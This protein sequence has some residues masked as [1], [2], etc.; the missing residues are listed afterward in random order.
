VC[1]E[2]VVE[3]PHDRDNLSRMSDTEDDVSNLGYLWPSQRGWMVPPMMRDLDRLQL[4]NQI[5]L[6]NRQV[7]K[8]G[9]RLVQRAVIDDLADPFAE[10]RRRRV[11]TV[12]VYS[13][14]DEDEF[15]LMWRLVKKSIK[16]SE[17]QLLPY[18]RHLA[19]ESYG[20]VLFA[21]TPTAVTRS[22][23]IEGL[24]EGSK[25]VFKDVVKQFGVGVS[26]AAIVVVGGMI[27]L[28][29]LL[30]EKG[31]EHKTQSAVIVECPVGEAL[32]VNSQMLD[33]RTTSELLKA[34]NS[35]C[36]VIGRFDLHPD[37]K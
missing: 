10:V 32:N 22:E 28:G 23:F 21:E 13:Q 17:Y 31:D 26:T 34:M 18:E 6:L 5:E 3:R 35:H 7:Y 37:K 25:D 14:G 24:K 4:V 2:R 33:A 19:P 11:F 20:A 36:K 15:A 8:L 29:H 1:V 30:P 12:A 9:D 27:G 16:N